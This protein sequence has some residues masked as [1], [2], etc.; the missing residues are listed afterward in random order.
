MYLSTNKTGPFRPIRLTGMN[1]RF[2]LTHCSIYNRYCIY[3]NNIKNN[4]SGE[5]CHIVLLVVDEL[6]YEPL[7]KG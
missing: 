7:H 2:V 3:Y 1:H 6:T 5:F 4:I